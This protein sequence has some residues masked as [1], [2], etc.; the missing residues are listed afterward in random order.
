MGSQKCYRPPLTSILRREVQLFTFKSVANMVSNGVQNP[1]H[2]SFQVSL[3]CEAAQS[4]GRAELDELGPGT[5]DK[6]AQ[7]SVIA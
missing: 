3:D 6:G 5:G 4:S 7:K 2:L 1:K